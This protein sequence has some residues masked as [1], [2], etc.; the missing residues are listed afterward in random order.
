MTDSNVIL[1]GNGPSLKQSEFGSTIDKFD[2]VVRFNN[3]ETKGYE[4]NVGSKTDIWSTRVCETVKNR[5][6]GEFSKI[7]G[8]V[9]YCIYTT[10]IERLVPSFLMSYE[11]ATIINKL[12]TK[13]YSKMFGYDRNKNWLT[14][15]I[16]TLL[17]LLDNQ[18]DHVH[19]CGFSGD[20]TKHYFKM[21][22]KDPQFHNF[23][24]EAAYIKK[25]ENQGKVTILF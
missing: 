20:T 16:I 8:V 12:I 7:F 24:M 1:V 4:R 6:E 15:G 3:Y 14:V 17:Y 2:T 25:L 18:Y 19:L 22:P 23:E 13:G 10:A 5:D 9:N 21:D 11:K